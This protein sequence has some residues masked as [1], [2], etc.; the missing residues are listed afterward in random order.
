MARDVYRFLLRM[1]THLREQLTDA[2]TES[3]RSLNAEIVNRL[4]ESLADNPGVFRRLGLRISDA[5]RATGER[6]PRER[7]SM[8]PEKN[9]RRAT[10]RRRL[11]FG[12]V[13]AAVVLT[14]AMVVGALSLNPKSQTAS[15]AF[16]QE[17]YEL[18]PAMRQ[19]LAN[20]KFSPGEPQ[21]ESGE[22]GD[23]DLEWQ[24]HAAPGTEI[25]MAAITGS[26]A[27][28][29]ALKAR[30]NAS[31]AGNGKWTNLGPDNAVYPLNPSR[32]RF[33]YVPNEYVAAG[34]TAHSAHRSE[35]SS[36]R[37]PL[38]DRQRGRWRLA[39]ERSVRR[40]AEVGV[41]VRRLPAQQHRRARARSQRLDEQ[42]DLRGHR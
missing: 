22:S 6:I 32:N 26:R 36:G 38:L 29:Q 3:G 28:W 25:P 13:A 2:T 42:R 1:P 33:V 30:G 24:M 15:P 8:S 16:A 14:T 11:V 21:R 40:G 7:R 39:D 9:S 20:P 23:G 4:E 35:L 34:R 27:D 41:P 5:W 18:S 10:R 31:I 12:A 17:G 19:K 37:L